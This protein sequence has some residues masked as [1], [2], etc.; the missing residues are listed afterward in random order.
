MELEADDINRAIQWLNAVQDLNPTYLEPGDIALGERLKD[1]YAREVPQVINQKVSND[2]KVGDYVFASRWSDC[3]PGDP[4]AVGH[5]AEVHMADG[6]KATPYP[7]HVTLS[8]MPH[9]SWPHAMRITQEQGQRIVTEM[10]K[11]ESQKR[12]FSKVAEVFGVQVRR[13]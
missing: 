1:A 7:G 12:D 4:W 6:G 2:L 5:I 10:P 9:R 13:R 3:D 8:E 11:M